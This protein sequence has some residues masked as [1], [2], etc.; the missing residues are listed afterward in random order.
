MPPLTLP[1]GAC[2]LLPPQI[3][4]Y[5]HHRG[6]DEG[7]ESQPSTVRFFSP[8][9]SFIDYRFDVLG[10]ACIPLGSGTSYILFRFQLP[11]REG[12]YDIAIPDL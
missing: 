11:W 5:A 1:S 4:V 7:G 12:C 9:V 10:Q 6:C 2:G 3:T 8:F